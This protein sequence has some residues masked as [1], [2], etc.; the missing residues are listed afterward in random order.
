VW[1]TSQAYLRRD[2]SAAESTDLE[3]MSEWELLSIRPRFLQ[4]KILDKNL[5]NSTIEI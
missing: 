5:H 2:L 4:T 1:N 3:E